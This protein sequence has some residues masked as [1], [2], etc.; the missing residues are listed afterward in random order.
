MHSFISSHH[1]HSSLLPPLG[2]PL[3]S[4]LTCSLTSCWKTSTFSHTNTSRHNPLTSALIYLSSCSFYYLK[5]CLDFIDDFTGHIVWSWIYTVLFH[6][7]L[8]WFLKQQ[9][10]RFWIGGDAEP[11]QSWQMMESLIN[12]I[13]C[14]HH[15]PEKLTLALSVCEHELAEWFAAKGVLAFQVKKASSER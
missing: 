12:L 9:I 8:T 7:D 13:Y 10:H 3:L 1:D 11:T 2:A 5:A 15:R 4:R 14:H 6:R